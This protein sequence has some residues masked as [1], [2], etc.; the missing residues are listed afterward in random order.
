VKHFFLKEVFVCCLCLCEQEIFC[1]RIG[2]K[3][4]NKVL[5]RRTTTTP[6]N[7]VPIW[8]CDLVHK[9]HWNILLLWES[10]A[11]LA[12]VPMPGYQEFWTEKRVTL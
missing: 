10:L 6:W 7:W 1:F 2:R 9:S 3:K 12:D 8:K 4:K 5:C 11:K